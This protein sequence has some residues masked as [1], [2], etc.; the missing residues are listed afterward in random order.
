MKI[1]IVSD[2]HKHNENM[3]QIL[4]DIG[5]LDM[6][7]HCGDAEGAE[8]IIREKINCPLYIVSGNNDFFSEL[9]NEIVF[10]IEEK[11]ILLTHGHYYYVSMGM[12][13]LVEEAKSRDID[14]VI[15]GHTHRP[16]I[17]NI[18]GVT[19]LN[20]GSI[21]YPRQNDKVPTYI[22]METDEN[23]DIYF[24]LNYFKRKVMM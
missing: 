18:D 14:I 17:E 5:Q 3:F 24:T 12:D 23:G 7:I 13:R 11:N 8:H 2:T 19:V 16:H 10:N 9:D 15:Y 21:S 1:L 6:V 4:E 20:P 22:L